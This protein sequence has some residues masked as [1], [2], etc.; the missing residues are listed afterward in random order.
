MT[1]RGYVETLLSEKDFTSQY[2]RMALRL[3]SSSAKNARGAAIGRVAAAP[4]ATVEA[5]P[6]AAQEAETVLRQRMVGRGRRARAPVRFCIPSAPMRPLM[7]VV[8]LADDEDA[9][10]EKG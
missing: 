5:A 2:V 10:V 7:E 8:A 4:I 6:L 1:R 9:A 3:P